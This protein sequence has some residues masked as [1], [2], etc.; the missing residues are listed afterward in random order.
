MSTY[1]YFTAGRAGAL[2]SLG[3]E[4]FAG[5]KLRDLFKL[6]QEGPSVFKA[7]LGD[8]PLNRVVLYPGTSQVAITSALPEELR[9]MGLGR[10]LYGELMRR[11]PN[12][13]LVS[14]THVSQPARKVWRAMEASHAG[15]DSRYTLHENANF[16]APSYERGPLFKASLPPQAAHTQVAEGVTPVDRAVPNTPGEKEI[17]AVRRAKDAV[18]AESEKR[19]R[20][21]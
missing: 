10:K 12:Q 16:E 9:G 13:T 14:D 20:R 17:N 5:S 18:R 11:M 6:V 21:R 19:W 7:Y 8:K 4:K 3:L 2:Q 1:V 15:R